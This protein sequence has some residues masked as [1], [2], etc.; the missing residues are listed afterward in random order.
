MNRT[1]L[2]AEAAEM[3]SDK[4]GIRTLTRRVGD[5]TITDV[6]ISQRAAER[7]GK[8]MGRYITLE[9]DPLSECMTALLRRAIE[10]LL[11]KCSRLL[12]AGLGNPDIT[13]DTLGSVA[14]RKLVAGRGMRY[15]LAAIETDVALRTGIKT[16]ALIRAAARESGSG[17]VLAIDSLACRSP[18]HIG[19]TVQISSA[20][21]SP[22][23][24]AGGKGAELSRRTVCVPVVAVGVPTMA[25]LSSITRREADSG[26]AVTAGDINIITEQWAEVISGAINELAGVQGS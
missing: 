8:P 16:P 4:S 11:P 21:I 2:A 14:V 3:L 6:C 1:D 20:G 19:R 13:H 24:G 26:Y 18:L 23:S 25:C 15:Y 10:Q 12:A 22:G 7:I 5:I 9:G 17:C